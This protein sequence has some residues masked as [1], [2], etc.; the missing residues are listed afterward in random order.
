MKI[1]KKFWK[2]LSVFGIVIVCILGLYLYRLATSA[3]YTTISLDK[4]ETKIA[5][6]DDFV[7]VTGAA[8]TVYQ[9]TIETYLLKHRGT[10]VYYLDLSSLAEGTVLPDGMNSD[11][12]NPH[13]YIYVDGTMTERR[14]GSIGYFTFDKV[15]SNFKE[16]AN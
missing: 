11:T 8:D 3:E 16:Q 2:E 13:T 9:T 14:D 1:V 5:N 10:H 4:L 6:G 15:M 12:T 7:L